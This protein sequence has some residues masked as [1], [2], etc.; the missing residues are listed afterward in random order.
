MLS[1]AP[2]INATLYGSARLSYCIARDGQL[3]R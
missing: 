1:T 3:P 2:A